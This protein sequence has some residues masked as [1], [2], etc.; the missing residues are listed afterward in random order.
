MCPNEGC[1]KVQEGLPFEDINILIYTYLIY[2]YATEVV[3]NKV[4]EEEVM[5]MK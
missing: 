1:S 3:V 4:E 2:L 5:S